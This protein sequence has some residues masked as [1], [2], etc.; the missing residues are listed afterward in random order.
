M[1][2]GV[3][4][5]LVKF[6]LWS[7]LSS[8][9][10]MLLEQPMGQSLL[11]GSGPLEVA[12][13][14]LMLEGLSQRSLPDAFTG[15]ERIAFEVEQAH[16]GVEQQSVHTALHDQRKQSPAE[17]EPVEAVQNARDGG[18]E[19]R[20]EFLHDGVFLEVAGLGRTQVL[21]EAAPSL[22][23]A[24]ESLWTVHSSDIVNV[25]E[26]SGAAQNQLFPSRDGR[27][28]HVLDGERR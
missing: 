19:P 4:K 20:Y 12:H 1:K 24:W 14:P 28:V 23:Q 13:G 27:V 5:V 9:G 8:S 25:T 26:L 17:H 6:G 3:S 21:R 22:R 15:R 18:A 10:E 2:T 16:S 11:V 7:V